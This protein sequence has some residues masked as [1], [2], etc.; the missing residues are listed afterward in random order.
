MS[1]SAFEQYIGW[2]HWENSQAFSFYE[3]TAQNLFYNLEESLSCETVGVWMPSSIDKSVTAAVCE[4]KSDLQN[5]KIDFWIKQ[6]W[7][8]T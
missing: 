6:A 2:A 5:G 7:I 3:N 4:W 1:S 8:K